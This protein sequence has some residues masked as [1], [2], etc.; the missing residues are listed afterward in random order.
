[1]PPEQK[2][3]VDPDINEQ[4][5]AIGFEKVLRSMEITEGHALIRAEDG[6]AG[7]SSQAM[8]TGLPEGSAGDILY[9]DGSDWVVLAAGEEGAV[10][11]ITSGVPA[12]VVP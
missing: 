1:M 3:Q 4:N 12:W 2:Q 9:H 11:T 6:L 8:P 5:V 10:L 7:L